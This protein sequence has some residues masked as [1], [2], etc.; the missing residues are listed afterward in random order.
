MVFFDGT[1]YYESTTNYVSH[2]DVTICCWIYPTE[3]AGSTKYRFFGAANDFEL[4]LI[5]GALE[6][7]IWAATGSTSIGT[8]P[9]NTWTHVVVTRDASG[10]VNIYFNGALDSTNTGQNSDPGSNLLKI[11]ASP[12]ILTEKFYGNM[13]DV[14]IYDRVLTATEVEIMYNA[15]GR[16]GI[17]DNLRHWWV[18]DE[19][20]IDQE[21]QYIYCRAGSG[22]ILQY[23]KV[24][25]YYPQF[26]EIIGCYKQDYL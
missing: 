7:D 17:I 23:Q 1:N 14:R 10:N 19:G 18:F 4:K 9:V 12:T 13:E 22:V 6:Q 16:D 3:Q 26:K 21:I 5:A 25:T 15:N 20:Y 11:G 2:A 8:C 24:S